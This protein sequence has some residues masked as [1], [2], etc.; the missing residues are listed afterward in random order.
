[1]LKSSNSH[2]YR[3]FG[4]LVCA[5]PVFCLGLT[6]SGLA[7]G[8]GGGGGGGGLPSGGS[9]EEQ[10]AV[11]VYQKGEERRTRGIEFLREAAGTADPEGK[12]KALKNANKQFKRAL[13]E[14]KRAT[15]RSRKFYQAYNE[16]GF[17]QRMLGD[18]ESALKA[19]DKALEIK[20]GFPY[21]IEYRGEAYMRLGRI[22]DVQGAYMELFGDQR[23]LADLLMAK[24][25]AWVSIE[26]KNPS[27]AVSTEALQGF[28][29]WIE[30]RSRIAE[31]TAALIDSEAPRIW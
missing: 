5:I 16:I 20:P 12:Q 22:K 29:T 27:G 18:Y 28:A 30:E 13:R 14:F 1:M 10:A 9:S 15:R 3:V 17:V 31:Q 11:A 19:Y 24:M 2:R 26:T 21:A 6:K 8:G 23:Q 4:A 7:A 25:K